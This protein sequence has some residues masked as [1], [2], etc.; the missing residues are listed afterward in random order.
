M[1]EDM[2]GWLGA[3][4]LYPGVAEALRA[5]VANPALDLYIVTTK[6]AR[7]THALLRD[8]G[9]VEMPMERIFSQTASGRPKTEVLEKLAAGVAPGV[10]LTFVEDKMSTLEAVAA[11]PG[12]EAWQLYLADWGYNT[13]EERARTEA[14]GS[15]IR[16]VDVYQFPAL[17]QAGSAGYARVKYNVPWPDCLPK[18]SRPKA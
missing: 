12:F 13:R 5:V 4:R 1:R 6:Q 15:R 16:L 10:R 14:T 17:L 18:E 9:G 7:F 2:A 3:N 8:L 11:A